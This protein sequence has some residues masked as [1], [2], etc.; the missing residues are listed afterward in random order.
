MQR[1]VHIVGGG[2]AGTEAAL[3]LA[4]A[5]V[6]VALHEQKPERRSPAHKEDGLAELVCSN[7]LRSDN[8]HNAVG[9]LHEELRRLGS[10]VLLQA[11][12]SRVP[13]GDALAVDRVAFSGGLSERVS[14]HPHI[15]VIGGEVRELPPPPDLCIVATGPLTGE[16]LARS[17]AEA[18]G[19]SQLAFYD[20]IAPIVAGDSV[21]RAVAFA[22]SR[23]G[24]GGGADYLNLPLTR[25]E[26]ERFVA[27]LLAGEK[28][29]PHGFE[30]PRYF[31]GCLPI[32]VMAER[33]R[34]VLAFGP[35]KPV[36]LTD[37]RTG[38][39]PHAVVQ[40]RREDRAGTAWNLVGFQT[41]L[42]WPEQKRIFSSCIPGLQKAEWIRLGQV[43]RNTF[44][45]APGVIA[46]DGSLKARP[47]VYC[48]GQI[49]GV[50]GYVESAASGHIC[51][52]R[53]L[54]RLQGR[55]LLPPPG[56]TAIGALLRHVTGEAHP[57]DYDY[58]PTN[59]VHALFPPLDERHRKHERKQRLMARARRDLVTWAAE[60]GVKLGPEPASWPSSELRP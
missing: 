25:D 60:S 44:L 1:E 50:E 28:V 29:K 32:E 31:E 58:Q 47:H 17:L 40:L 9:L 38:A 5:G 54:A 12:A 39:R 15:R 34:D 21:D 19:A 37:P 52:R 42:T 45:N 48:A 6:Q 18:V 46:R 23:Y 51:A 3:L 30:E 7:S 55:Q 14:R 26:Y 8:P 4:D 22:A 33:G 41:R 24:K 20:A 10:P 36:G 13:A 35:M 53:I 49:T 27:E 43:H 16:D 59:V 57:P 56:T 11:D 2:L